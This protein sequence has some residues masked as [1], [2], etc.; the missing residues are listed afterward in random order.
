[1]FA[2]PRSVTGLLI[3]DIKIHSE[4]GIGGKKVRDVKLLG[5][6]LKWQD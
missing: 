5:K 1:M 2:S 3:Y 6:S 4:Y